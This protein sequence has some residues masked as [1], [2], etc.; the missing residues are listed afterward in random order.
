MPFSQ[1]VIDLIGL[2]SIG[3]ILLWIWGKFFDFMVEY[4]KN[5]P[6]QSSLRRRRLK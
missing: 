5:N 3:C 6:N 2:V 4:K 1:E